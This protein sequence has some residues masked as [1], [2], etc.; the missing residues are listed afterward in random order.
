MSKD[1]LP[2]LLL[3]ENPSSVVLKLASETNP[4]LCF[5]KY[6]KQAVH[7]NPN[8]MTLILIAFVILLKKTVNWYQFFKIELEAAIRYHTVDAILGVI[9][10]LTGNFKRIF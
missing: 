4:I 7:K 1:A 6:K 9:Y 10:L 5:D 3:I 8:G 2:K